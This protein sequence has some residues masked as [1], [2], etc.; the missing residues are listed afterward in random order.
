M[1]TSF[2]H[3]AAASGS[4]STHSTTHLII[5]GLSEAPNVRTSDCQEQSH[6][7]SSPQWPAFREDVEQS[8]TSSEAYTLPRTNSYVDV[9]SS[10]NA[11]DSSDYGGSEACSLPSTNSYVDVDYCNADDSGVCGGRDSS[12]GEATFKRNN[13]QS[14]G[15]TTRAERQ[16]RAPAPDKEPGGSTGRGG[17]RDCRRLPARPKPPVG[18][19]QGLKLE[20]M[21]YTSLY[22]QRVAPIDSQSYKALEPSKMQLTTLY[23]QLAK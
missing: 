17:Q 2:F 1:A 5:R 6:Y 19:Y 9:D 22:S 16:I 14:A 7:Y 15:A 21:D 13:S 12:S 10:F 18:T 8:M 23:T 11:D 4:G 20:T 3:S